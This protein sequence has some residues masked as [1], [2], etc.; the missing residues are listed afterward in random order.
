MFYIVSNIFSLIF[1]EVLISL[2]NGL[3]S[4]HTNCPA[5]MCCVFSV[6]KDKICHFMVTLIATLQKI[7]NIIK[8]LYKYNY[9]NYVE[10]SAVSR[11]DTS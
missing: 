7:Y 8:I 1:N 2:Y 4:I 5:T 6:T 9:I 10:K 3:Y 11:E